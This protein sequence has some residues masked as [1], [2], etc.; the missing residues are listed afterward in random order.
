MD[1]LG[2]HLLIA[3]DMSGNLVSEVFCLDNMIH[4]STNCNY[5][6]TPT[7]NLVYE[8]CSDMSDPVNWQTLATTAVAGA[9]GGQLWLDRNAP[10]KYL[11]VTYAFTAGVGTL[12]VN[13][14]AKGDL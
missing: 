10:Y 3:G 1:T 4:V 14:I 8:V 6:G 9:A 2:K 12:D 5:V 11:R 7:G 13:I